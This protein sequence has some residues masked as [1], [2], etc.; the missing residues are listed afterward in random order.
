MKMGSQTKETGVSV[1]LEG[2]GLT[3]KYASQIVGT[4]QSI[5]DNDVKYIESS[6]GKRTFII[7]R[8]GTL[9]NCVIFDNETNKPHNLIVSLS[10]ATYDG[11][12]L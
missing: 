8:Y 1:T 3:A 11:A 12:K 5:N 7:T 4:I 10:G 2:I 6:D 9:V